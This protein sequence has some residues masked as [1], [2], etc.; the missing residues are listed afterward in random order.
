MSQPDDI[1]DLEGR[2]LAAVGYRRSDRAHAGGLSGGEDRYVSDTGIGNRWPSTQD[3]EAKSVG[4]SSDLPHTA[5]RHPTAVGGA[6]GG[7]PQNNRTQR[8]GSPRSVPTGRWPGGEAAL[9][10]APPRT[11]RVGL[12]SIAGSAGEAAR[13]RVPDEPPGEA[14]G[15]SRHQTKED[16]AD[17][18][19]PDQ[20][21]LG[22][23]GWSSGRVF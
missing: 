5:T 3:V 8:R 18:A 16:G 7:A 9:R 6:S 21:E 12:Q 15:I 4:G 13:R 14:G 19:F 22:L 11:Q 10:A 20:P 1:S 2:E 23:Q 17:A